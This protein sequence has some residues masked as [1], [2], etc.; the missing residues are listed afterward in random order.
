V[1]LDIEITSTLLD[2][3]K[4]FEGLTPSEVGKASRRAINRTLLTLR[5]ESI[6]RIP[7]KIKIKA[8]TLRERYIT[9]NKAQG[10]TNYEGSIEFSGAP[11][12]LL[13]FVKGSKEPIKQEGIKIARRR[14]L[15]VEITPGKKF[16]LRK[17]FIQ[18]VQ[19]KQVFKRAQGQGNFKK[20]GAPSVGTVV[21]QKGIGKEL[22]DIGA[23]R[24]QELFV[25]DLNARIN[26]FVPSDR[27]TKP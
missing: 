22:V 12:P 26:G 20:Q 19:S 21:V 7:E 13:E 1:S 8:K 4:M 15:K 3:A 24:F 11:I 5:K 6:K 17:A 2:A 18:R 23:S 14:K 16:T 27:F 10:G 9:L 25:A